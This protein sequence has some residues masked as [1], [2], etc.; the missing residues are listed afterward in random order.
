M[1]LA[2]TRLKKRIAEFNA[3]DLSKMNSRQDP[4][5]VGI[6]RGIDD[7][8]AKVFGEGTAQYSR[9]RRAAAAGGEPLVSNSIN[10]PSPQV[11]LTHF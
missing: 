7:T 3:L 5:L 8:L 11:R 4:E 2:I 6:G 9:Y 1:R 10:G